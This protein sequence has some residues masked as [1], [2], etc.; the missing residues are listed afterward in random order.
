M[1]NVNVIDVNAE[2][3]QVSERACKNELV[4]DP[5]ASGSMSMIVA[6]VDQY[7]GTVD[8]NELSFNSRFQYVWNQSL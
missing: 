7:D 4:I 6:S 3:A 2:V 1:S 5:N 8:D